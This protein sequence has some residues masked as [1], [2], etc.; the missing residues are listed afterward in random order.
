MKLDQK[1]KYL[2]QHN[3]DSGA[4]HTDAMWE[5]CQPHQTPTMGLHSNNV[6]RSYNGRQAAKAGL[7]V[8]GGHI[9]GARAEGDVR[10]G[11]SD[12]VKARRKLQKAKTA[13]NRAA[14]KAALVAELRARGYSV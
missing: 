5:A 2:A 11:N 4:F 8:S 14:R 12:T 7:G 1:V 13:R 3:V 6:K 9:E 10:F